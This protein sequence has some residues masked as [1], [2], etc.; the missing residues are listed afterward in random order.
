MCTLLY[1]GPQGLLAKNRDK[2]DEAAEEVLCG[3]DLVGVRSCGDDHFSIAVNRLGV[4]FAGTAVRDPGW[5]AAVEA[6]DGERAGR[7]A[8]AEQEGRISPARVMSRLLPE[9]GDAETL[10]LGL[11]AAGGPWLGYHIVVADSHG[12]LVLELHDHDHHRRPL[13]ERDA[14]TNHFR[15]LDYGP[16]RLE[17]YP[18]SFARLSVA[19]RAMEAATTP[20]DLWGVLRSQEAG[21][22]PD[23]ILRVGAFRTVSS[24]V[25]DLTAGCIYHAPGLRGRAVRHDLRLDPIVHRE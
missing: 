14:V 11:L 4:G 13:A 3:H 12:G 2:P 19:R 18:S 10:A 9:A 1:L 23:R 21:E 24:A 8:D 5:T 15:H 6:G 17:D 20:E 7:M 22:G 16:R 25:A